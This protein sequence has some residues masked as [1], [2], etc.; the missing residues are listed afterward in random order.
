MHRIDA[1]DA[2]G[3]FKESPA[4][5]TKVT[6]AWMNDIQENIAGVIEAAGIVL[7]K[8]S[9]GQLLAAIRFF[10]MPAGALADFG[11]EIVPAGW[12]EAD[13]SQKLIAGNAALYAAIGDRYGAADSGYFR[14]PD[15]RGRYRRGWDN[16]AGRDPAA[17]DVGDVYDDQV[18]SHGHSVEQ[19]S[20]PGSAND[21][22]AGGGVMTDAAGGP[23]VDWIVPSVGAAETRVKTLITMT[24]I[25]R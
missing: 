20:S 12:Y 10:G 17:P 13:G 19:A 3:L 21:N 25:K 11:G 9:W 7:A 18:G 8:G 16:G 5:A 6:A 24:I 1:D 2:D 15:A 4:P 23:Q 22:T 14:L